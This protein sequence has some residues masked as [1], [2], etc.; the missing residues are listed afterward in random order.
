MTP[1]AGMAFQ[2]PPSFGNLVGRWL[3]GCPGTE[4][5]MKGEEVGVIRQ[6]KSNISHLEVGELTHLLTIDPTFHGTS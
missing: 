1:L 6:T 5:R 2:A 4:V 3:F